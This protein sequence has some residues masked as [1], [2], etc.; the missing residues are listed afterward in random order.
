M[1]DEQIK[2]GKALIKRAFWKREIFPIILVSIGLI[3]ILGVVFKIG[4]YS[5]YSEK[6]IWYGIAGSI[7][8][9]C[10]GIILTIIN[11]VKLKK[12]DP[13]EARQRLIK[14]NKKPSKE[15]AETY[16]NEITKVNKLK[17]QDNSNIVKVDIYIDEYDVP[18]IIDNVKVDCFWGDTSVY[19][20]SGN[21]KICNHSIP[22]NDLREFF[23]VIK[24]KKKNIGIRLVTK[25]EF[26]KFLKARKEREESAR[27]ART[28]V[29]REFVCGP[30]MKKEFGAIMLGKDDNKR[31]RV[32]EVM[33]Y[34]VTYEDGHTGVEEDKTFIGYSDL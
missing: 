8:F 7:L 15:E 31:Y 24:G 19:L 9:I 22:F 34:K 28:V 14:M 10:A 33:T 25:T 11:I 2:E 13:I 5:K 27:K 23:L 21:H 26:E 18:L 3:A 32:Y 17:Y 30:I 6:D 29:K 20:Q 4:D 12:I 1:E 16:L